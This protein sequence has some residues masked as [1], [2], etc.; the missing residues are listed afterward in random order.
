MALLLEK[1]YLQF[2]MMHQIHCIMFANF[3]HQWLEQ[4]ILQM[5][6]QQ[7]LQGLLDRQAHKVLKV[8]KDPLAQLVL[9]EQ[10]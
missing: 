1:L 8:S 5:L 9:L 10:A 6:G 3:I 2:L 4:S 7:G